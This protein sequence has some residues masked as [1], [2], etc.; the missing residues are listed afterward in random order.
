MLAWFDPEHWQT[1]SVAPQVVA[2]DT[3]SAIHFV[4]HAGTTADV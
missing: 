2:E 3:A 4:A 1:R